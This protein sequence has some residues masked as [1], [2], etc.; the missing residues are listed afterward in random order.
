MHP[1]I[2]QKFEKTVATYSEKF[3]EEIFLDLAEADFSLKVGRA[4]EEILEQIV[5]KMCHRSS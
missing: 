4:G 5:I 1:Y 2:A 3:L